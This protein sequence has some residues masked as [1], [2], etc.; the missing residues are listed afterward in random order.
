MGCVVSVTVPSV[1]VKWMK[2]QNKC[3]TT[4]LCFSAHPPNPAAGAWQERDRVARADHG[5]D[6]HANEFPTKMP[7]PGTSELGRV[8]VRLP[9]KISDYVCCSNP[10]F[11]ASNHPL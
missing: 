9:C 6:T 2:N 4:E 1:S 8:C 10:P 3:D 7:T 5:R 11:R